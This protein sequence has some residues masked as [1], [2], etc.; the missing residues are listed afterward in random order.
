MIAARILDAKS[1][2]ARGLD[3]NRYRL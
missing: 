2:R 1:P 3:Q